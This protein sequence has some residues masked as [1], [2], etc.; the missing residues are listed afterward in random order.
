MTAQ[1][2]QIRNKKR[3][4]QFQVPDMLPPPKVPD[5]LP[6]PRVRSLTKTTPWCREVRIHG[7]L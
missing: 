6:P 1:I 3:N 5:M 2:L 4:S 7:R